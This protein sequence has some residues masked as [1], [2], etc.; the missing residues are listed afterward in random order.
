MHRSEAATSEAVNSPLSAYLERFDEGLPEAVLVLQNLLDRVDAG[1]LLLLHLVFSGRDGLLL[2]GQRPLLLAVLGR[3]DDFLQ[4]GLQPQHAPHL[5][6]L[7]C[8]SRLLGPVETDLLAVVL[9][10]H[11]LELH[12]RPTLASP[13]AIQHTQHLRDH[14]CHLGLSHV[15]EQ[16]AEHVRPAAG[17]SDPRE[18]LLDQLP[19]LLHHG[20]CVGHDLHDQV[21]TDTLDLIDDE[22]RDVQRVLRVGTGQLDGAVEEHALRV[23]DEHV[24]Q[25]I[26][27]HI[28]PP[29]RAHSPS[30]LQ[31]RLPHGRLLRPESRRRAV[32]QV[33][34]QAFAVGR[35]VRL[36]GGLQHGD[37][38]LPQRGLS[39]IPGARFSPKK[40]SEITLSTTSSFALFMLDTMP[41]CR[42]DLMLGWNP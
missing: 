7:A 29:V 17:A 2:R 39:T 37:Q 28:I 31:Q 14:A 34:R 12:A 26:A 3:P 36:R 15:V 11:L 6:H 9:G 1:V 20:A 30:V 41:I 8:K 5:L 32:E 4:V 21:G 25:V 18:L 24:D 27:P 33:R 10:G 22:L 19:G 38:L 40:A 16:E 23:A 35:L 42:V 13:E